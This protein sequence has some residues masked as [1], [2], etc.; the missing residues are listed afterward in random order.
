MVHIANVLPYVLKILF[1]AYLYTK[2][3]HDEE[4]LKPIEK[5]KDF[6]TYVSEN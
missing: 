6:N 5:Y 1:S 2:S 4:V 3:L